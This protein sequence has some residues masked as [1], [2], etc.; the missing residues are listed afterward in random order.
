MDPTN[1]R[2]PRRP[3][4][5]TTSNAYT[6]YKNGQNGQSKRS[7]RTKVDGEPPSKRARSGSARPGSVVNGGDDAK[8]EPVTT[9]VNGSR[10]KRRAAE[11]APDYYAWNHGISAP[12]NKWL[13]LISDPEKYGKVILDGECV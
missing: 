8:V 5:A 2:P 9:P 7:A 12:T 3:V 1:P 6:R 11:N 4:V 13:Q 10:P